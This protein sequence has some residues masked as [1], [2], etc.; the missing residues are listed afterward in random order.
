MRVSNPSL[1]PAGA[2]NSQ[3]HV[4]WYPERDLNS[5]DPSG[6]HGPEPCASAFR[7]RGL[8]WMTGLEPAAC[9]LARCR[10]ANCATSTW[11]PQEVP[12]LWPRPYQGRAPPLSYEGMHCAPE[13]GLE[14]VCAGTK[15]QPGFLQ[16]TP[17]WSRPPVPTRISRLTGARSQPC[18]T[19]KC[20][21]RDSD[22]HG[23]CGPPAPRADA[24]TVP[25]RALRAATRCRPGPSA[26]RRQS[27]SRARRPS[28]RARTRTSIRGF[29]VRCPAIRRPGIGGRGGI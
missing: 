8:E 14:P 19:A 26:V 5:H 2:I 20:A 9:T 27:R 15:A 3:P 17:E 4:P 13:T 18:A 23:P 29:R 11:S 21:R 25:P 16:P 22:P 12:I 24:S 7:H 28:C 1:E 6:S 10:A